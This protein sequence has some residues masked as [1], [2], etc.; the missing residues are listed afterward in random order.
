M[1]VDA[2]S[3]GMHGVRVGPVIQTH[4]TR[5]R[6]DIRTGARGAQHAK[7]QW[8]RCTQMH[9]CLR[10][11]K[12]VPKQ[13]QHQRVQWCC[14]EVC[15]WWWPVARGNGGGVVGGAQSERTGEAEPHREVF[16]RSVLLRLWRCPCM[17]TCLPSWTAS[18]LAS[19]A[20]GFLCAGILCGCVIFRTK[21][22]DTLIRFVLVC[23]HTALYHPHQTYSLIQYISD[24][25]TVQKRVI[26]ASC[27]PLSVVQSE[28][29]RSGPH[30]KC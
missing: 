25:Q 24:S 14:V 17:C 21:C 29:S 10:L 8:P 5:V 28:C 20:N 1:S 13:P 9:E 27:Q 2:C 16:H 7:R 6:T 18:S 15:A 11:A 22:H 4:G 26:T 23:M 12:R 19:L 30:A 3:V